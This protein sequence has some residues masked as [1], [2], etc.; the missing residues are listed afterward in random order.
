MKKILYLV[1]A[2]VAFASCTHHP[3]VPKDY[4]SVNSQ[5]D[6]YPDYKDVV[7]PPNIAPLNFGIRGNVTDCVARFTFANNQS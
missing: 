7:V 1:I 5:P 6:I 3:E 4:T 2:A